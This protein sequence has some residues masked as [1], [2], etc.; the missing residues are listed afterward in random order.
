MIAITSH[1][2]TMIFITLRAL[3]IVF[4]H[5]L[6]AVQPGHTCLCPQHTISCLCLYLCVLKPTQFCGSQCACNCLTQN[7][8]C[9]RMVH[10]H[11]PSRYLAAAS[12][13]VVIII[14][15]IIFV[16]IIVIQILLFVCCCHHH[17]HHHHHDFHARGCRFRR[18]LLRSL[19]S[20]NIF[21]FS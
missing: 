17:H 4:L 7:C 8:I 5:L 11:T 21:F 13:P 18:L 3:S 12:T 1:M 20:V 2:M 14:I 10:V 9:A 19:K 15:I 16:I 6:T